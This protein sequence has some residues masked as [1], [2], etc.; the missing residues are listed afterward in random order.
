MSSL[1]MRMRSLTMAGGSGGG[2]VGA[3]G[4]ERVV[5]AQRVMRG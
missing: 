4:D 5:E 3:L 2:S 1:G